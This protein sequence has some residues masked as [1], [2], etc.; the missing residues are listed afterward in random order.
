MNAFRRVFAVLTV[1]ATPGLAHGAAAAEWW[2]GSFVWDDSMPACGDNDSIS[3]YSDTK[4]EMWEQSCEITK[5]TPLTNLKG[6]I[7]DLSCFGEGEDLGKRRE[8]LLDNGGGKLLS[9]PPAKLKRRC[10]APPPAMA[11][12]CDFNK[13]VYRAEDMPAP[14]VGTYQ[15]LRFTDGLASG[16]AK[17]T[18][19]INGKAAWS[20]DG[21]FACSN[22]ASICEVMFK[23]MLGGDEGSFPYEIVSDGDHPESKVVIPAWRQSIYMIER[24]ATNNGKPYGGLV[25]T[26]LEGFAPVNGDLTMP[27]NVYEFSRCEADKQ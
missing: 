6:I 27:F 16:S 3:T 8:I 15:E 17:L 7:L 9:F 1:A 20:A 12:S 19:F 11:A 4:V 5:K 13:R 22:G 18:H 2:H 21:T 14:R 10:D 25:A 23:T 24:N 26:L